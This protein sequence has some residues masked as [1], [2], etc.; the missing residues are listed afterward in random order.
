MTDQEIISAAVAKA[1]NHGWQGM[2]NPV[3]DWYTAVAL[4]PNTW[5]LPIIHCLIFNHT[6]ALALWGEQP[7]V[8]HHGNWDEP[9][10]MTE[11]HTPAWI[12]H[13]QKM[14]VSTDPI[15]YLEQYM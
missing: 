6:F 9:S 13:L 14:V 15:K 8:E 5:N 11:T 2:D 10:T 7:I 12:Y 1:L 3:E 4:A